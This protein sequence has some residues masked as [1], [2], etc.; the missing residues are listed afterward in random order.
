MLAAELRGVHGELTAAGINGD[1][2]NH[3]APML[4]SALA[5]DRRAIA[6]ERDRYR[7]ALEAIAASEGTCGARAR[8][9]LEGQS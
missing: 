3:W 7:A 8:K 2:E 1:P 6:A 4:V 9:A 5:R